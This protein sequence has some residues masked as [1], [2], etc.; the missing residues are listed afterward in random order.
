[1]KERANGYELRPKPARQCSAHPKLFG[2]LHPAVIAGTQQGAGH[3]QI[4]MGRRSRPLHD[5][6]A[7][8]P[9]VHPPVPDAR[10]AQG[11]PSHPALRPA[12]RPQRK[13]LF[14]R[15]CPRPRPS[16]HGCPWMQKPSEI[17]TVML[18]SQGLRFRHRLGRGVSG[19][20]HLG[21]IKAPRIADT[22]GSGDWCTAG[23]IAKVGATGL[24]GLRQAGVKGIQAGLRYG[25][26]LAAWNCGFEGARGGMYAVDRPAFDAQIEA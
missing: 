20:K 9:R 19:W 13:R 23:L 24:V 17:A 12:R 3:F 2:N 18:G 22:C 8:H 4:V 10:T 21:A 7:R 5:G 6:D 25:Q 11:I 15:R 14:N 1:M 26:A 16:N